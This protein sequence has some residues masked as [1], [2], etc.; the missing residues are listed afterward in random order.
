MNPLKEILR[1]VASELESAGY[2]W[3][4]IG[5]LAISARL[6]PRF[7]RDID[8]AISVVD[9]TAAEALVGRLRRQGFRIHSVLEQETT[10]RMATVRLQTS[11]GDEGPFV[12]LLFASSGIEPEVVAAADP[13]EIA[14][15]LTVPVAQL[16]HLLAMKVLARDD[17]R[18]PQDLVDIRNILNVAD[19][20]Q[21]NRAR[22]ALTLIAERGCGRGKDLLGD[23]DSLLGTLNTNRE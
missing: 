9:D 6:E 20:Q 13:L 10:D 11:A 4:L 2:R 14:T 21:L 17:E 15:G 23:L 12:D 8:L 1:S 5:G 3:A 18:R 19:S 7:T 16:G 22:L